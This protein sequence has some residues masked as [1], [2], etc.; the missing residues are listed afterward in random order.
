MYPVPKHRVHLAAFF[1]L[2]RYLSCRATAMQVNKE[3]LLQ[4]EATRQTHE[5]GAVD[6][7]PLDKGPSCLS[8][9]LDPYS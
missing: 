1:S 6:Q 9:G 8:T 4:H 7:R 2:L 5:T 3:Y